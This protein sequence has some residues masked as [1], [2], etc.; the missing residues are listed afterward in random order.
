M[1]SEEEA[2]PEFRAM[3][4]F[5]TDDDVNALVD[6]WSHTQPTYRW[7]SVPL[8]SDPLH[9]QVTCALCDAYIGLTDGMGD[10]LA[11]MCAQHNRQHHLIASLRSELSLK[12][13]KQALFDQVGCL[14][15][16]DDWVEVLQWKPRTRK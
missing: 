12:K 1:T 6:A 8:E 10:S 3:L 7:A 9:Y 14:R 11:R 15:S 5:L 13:F 16:K 4:L 2:D